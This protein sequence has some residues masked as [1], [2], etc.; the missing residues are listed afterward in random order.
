[1]EEY[2]RRHSRRS[3]NSRKYTGLRQILNVIFMLGAISGLCI[4]FFYNQTYGTI[5]ILISMMF[6]FVECA[7]RLIK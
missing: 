7:F 3:D 6:K 5:I 4:Y 2:S 1:M